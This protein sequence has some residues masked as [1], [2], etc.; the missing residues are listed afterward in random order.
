MT[1]TA[2]STQAQPHGR[3]EA[4]TLS[5]ATFAAL[6]RNHPAGVAVVTADA[7]EGPVAF[8]ASSLVS[9]SAEPA[10]L[11]FSISDA[12]T[13]AATLARASS[14]VV[15]FLGGESLEFL[16]QATRSGSDRFADPERWARLATG[17][18]VLREARAWIRGEIEHRLRAGTATL[19]LV[20]ALE[21]G[22]EPG[23]G[24]PLV[25]HDRGWHELG[26]HSRLDTSSP[27]V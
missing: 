2:P 12:T 11:S 25:Y 4:R 13:A 21:T 24:R 8:V 18:P 9:L 3:P 6:F 5:A 14:V 23:G 10:Y 15:H 19:H 26:P 27:D 22:G 16:R 17:E 20:R 7:G 1:L